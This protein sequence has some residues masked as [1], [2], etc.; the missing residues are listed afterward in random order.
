M[1]QLIRNAI[2]YS[3][4]LPEAVHASEHLSK[5]AFTPITENAAT[6]TGFEVNDKTGEMATPLVGMDGYF[7]TMRFDSKIIPNDVV[8][9]MTDD[10]AKVFALRHGRPASKKE[11]QGLKEDVIASLLP[12]A[13]VRTKRITA[14]YNRTAGLL[15]VNTTNKGLAGR[16]MGLVVHAIGSVKTSTIHISDLS[17]GLTT[18]LKSFLAGHKEAF[19]QNFE[20]TE[21]VKLVSKAG[22]GE[23]QVISYQIDNLETV[24]EAITDRIDA[25]YK[26]QDIKIFSGYTTFLLTSDFHMRGIEMP[27]TPDDGEGDDA[28]YALRNQYSSELFMVT[29]VVQ[30]MLNL[31]GYKPPVDEETE[32][33]DGEEE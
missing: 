20:P 6:S 29:G 2:I 27:S 17:N 18:R 12:T 28:A 33:S 3:A 19:A 14:V 32:D 7:F 26:V 4:E 16:L 23:K 24:S 21:R 22:E 8:K 13:P 11:R 5:I 1:T 9:S 10:L 25:G 30:E 15:F 31:F